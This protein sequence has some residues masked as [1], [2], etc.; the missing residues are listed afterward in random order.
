M[1]STL[2]DQITVVFWQRKF[3]GQNNDEKIADFLRH[4]V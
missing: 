4:G 2:N 1:M 3:R